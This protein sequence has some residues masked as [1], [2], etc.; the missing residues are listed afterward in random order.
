MNA[1]SKT[2]AAVTPAREPGDWAL[3]PLHLLVRSPFNVRKMRGGGI[4]ELA[5]LILAQGVLENILVYVEK[6]KGRAT[7]NYAVAAGDRRHQA[8]SLL[9]SSNK[10]QADHGVPCLIISEESAIELSL[11]ENCHEPMH[12]A[13]EFAAFQAMLDNGKTVEDIA[14]TFGVSPLVVQRRLK[15]ANVSPRMLALY[16]EGEADL[17]Q[18]MALAITD[19]HAAQERAWDSSPDHNRHARN[20]RRLLTASTID[21]KS[22]PLVAFIGV[23]SYEKAGGNVRR[24]LFSDE[25]G[26]YIEDATLLESLALA[27]LETEAEAIKAE[28]WCWVEA[29]TRCDHSELSSYGRARTVRREPSRKEATKLK[30][31]EQERSQIEEQMQSFEGEDE[32]YNEL[33]KR[34]DELYEQIEAV[35]ESLE[36]YAPSD[37]SLYGAIVTLNHA[38]ALDVRRGLLRSEDKRKVRAQSGD[39][40][41]EEK[42][43]PAHSER[44]TRQLTAHRTAALQASLAVRHDVALVVIAH[45][46]ATQLFGAVGYFRGAVQ[47]SAQSPELVREA[48]DMEQSRA[49]L[50]LAEQ[51]EAWERRL[52]LDNEEA[53]FAWLLEQPQEEV[54]ALLAY[55]TACTV[56]TVESREAGNPAVAALAGAL[57]LDM[58]DW[59]KPTR[60]SY[61]GHVPKSRLVSVVSEAV[62]SDAAKPLVS[63]KKGEAIAA[64]ELRLEGTRWL[65]ETLR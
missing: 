47:V 41:L 36:S 55:C 28:G 52:P 38:G 10:I 45:R 6:K 18:L 12:P 32:D 64:A 42:Q 17:D 26:G 19:D 16:R 25:G 60:D 48:A 5:A 15:L 59:W 40:G 35:E 22:D 39:D 33:D 37:L 29:R 9:A 61:L 50:S 23:E 4:P 1:K 21:L 27:K 13:D 44:L 53:F 20:L 56:N 30:A 8:L 51:R 3:I 2:Q 49:W 46:L 58:A 63:M 57:S 11:A 34:Y 54:L 65:P 31:L 14:A 7:G 62:S 24:D 43:N